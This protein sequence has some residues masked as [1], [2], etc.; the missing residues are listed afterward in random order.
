MKMLFRIQDNDATELR[1]YAERRIAFQF[2]RFAREVDTLALRLQDVNGPRGGIDKLCQVTLRG[3]HVGQLAL[4]ELAY[5][6]KEAIDLAIA[7]MARLVARQLAKART[8]SL[9]AGSSQ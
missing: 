9:S 8:M 5:S 2:S 7:R 3:P 6:T 1:K 4:A